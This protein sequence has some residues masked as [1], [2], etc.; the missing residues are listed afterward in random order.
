MRQFRRL[1]VHFTTSDAGV[2]RPAAHAID[3]IS[4]ADAKQ[5]RS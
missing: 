1:H 3:A 4:N 5:N 2:R